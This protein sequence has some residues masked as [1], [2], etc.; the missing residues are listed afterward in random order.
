M[1]EETLQWGGDPHLWKQKP[2]HDPTKVQAVPS[3]PHT[4]PR[5]PANR[6]LQLALPI[7]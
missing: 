5:T 2:S 6:Q 3:H 7:S 1:C 4:L